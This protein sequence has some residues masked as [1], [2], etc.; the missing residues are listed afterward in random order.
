MDPISILAS[1]A[2]VATAGTQVASALFSLVKAV[3]NAPREMRDIANEMTDLTCVLGHLHD[4]LL[5]GHS[6]S[7]PSYLGAIGAAI[8][9][10]ETTQ[11]EIRGLIDD[12]SYR[13]RLMWGKAS[14]ALLN[15]IGKHKITI[16]LQ[17]SILSLAIQATNLKYQTPPPRL[18]L[19]HIVPGEKRH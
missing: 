13:K 17:V 2:G 5:A 6:F 8:N 4:I 15:E 10:V 18:S 9:N 14:R 1:I 12:K 7:R 16:N 19:L 3:R 11:Q